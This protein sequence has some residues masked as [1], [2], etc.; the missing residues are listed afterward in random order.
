VLRALLPH[1]PSRHPSYCC[2][3]GLPFLESA[4]YFLAECSTTFTLIPLT[5]SA[6]AHLMY[7][8]SCIY[9]VGQST[10][11][12]Y[13]VVDALST[14]IATPVA[15]VHVDLQFSERYQYLQILQRIFPLYQRSLTIT[16][17][18]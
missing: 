2:H 18:R 4:Q 10:E 3:P 9:S 14:A 17:P 5:S 11:S 16:R 8:T 15:L 13:A 1:F 7:I 6:Y 12:S